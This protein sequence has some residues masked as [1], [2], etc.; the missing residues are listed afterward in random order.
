MLPKLKERRNA[1][2]DHPVRS[3]VLAL[4]V[5]AALLAGCGLPVATNKDSVEQR[6][7]K[8]EWKNFSSRGIMKIAS[9][10]V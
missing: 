8:E 10:Q 6:K 5:S 2:Q 4:A 7:Y 3:L 9:R 1:M